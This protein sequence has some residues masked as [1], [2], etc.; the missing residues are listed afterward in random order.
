MPQEVDYPALNKAVEQ[1]G[2]LFA[3]IALIEKTTNGNV[4]GYMNWRASQNVAAMKPTTP[5]DA[6]TL[7][8]TLQTIDFRNRGALFA[9]L[10]TLRE[11]SPYQL[12][13]DQTRALLLVPARSSLVTPV[14]P[15]PAPPSTTDD[16]D[17]HP[18]YLGL[19]SQVAAGAPA[20]TVR[21]P[22][23]V[24]PLGRLVWQD[25]KTPG[26]SSRQAPDSGDT[27]YILVVDVLSKGFP[28]WLIYDRMPYDRDL[29]DRVTIDPATQP[30]VFDPSI[31]NADSV[32]LWD[33]IATS[34]PTTPTTLRQLTANFGKG[35]REPV[36]V[37]KLTKREVATALASVS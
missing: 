12:A 2:G 3:S 32:C 14:D 4:K 17:L 15:A 6:K 34:W 16:D 11:F 30:P 29:D 33:S 5:A 10:Q 27:N 18:F 36:R 20:P 7:A 37:A 21:V 28:V 19:S 24:L 13:T 9:E 31:P 25:T 8:K 23:V 1:N 22:R 35:G 26:G